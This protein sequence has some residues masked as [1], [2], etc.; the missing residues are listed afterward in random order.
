MPRVFRSS[1]QLFRSQAN[2]LNSGDTLVFNC[3]G[4]ATITMAD[5]ITLKPGVTIDGGNA[6]TLD[7]QGRVRMR[8]MIEVLIMYLYIAA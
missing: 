4:A 6:I 3:G 2:L 1:L 7:G 8:Q 5:S